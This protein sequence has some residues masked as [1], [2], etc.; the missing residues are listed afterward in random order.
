MI[1]VPN[2]KIIASLAFRQIKSSWAKNI[3][4]VL[5]VI[6][7][8]MLIMSVLTIG[9]TLIKASK[10]TQMKNSG[11][12]AEVSFQYLL[13]NEADSIASS[14]L[15]ER[16]GISR[17]VAGVHDA[18]WENTPL[19]IRTADETYADMMY[20]TPTDGRLPE[21][22][23]E[24]AVKS[25]MLSDMGIPCETG[26]SFPVS[27]DVNG[28]HYDLELTVSGIW[29]DTKTLFPFAAAYI[30][31]ELAEEL[32]RGVNT[33]ENISN[34]SYIGSFQLN[35]DLDCDDTKLEETLEQ[36]VAECGIDAQRSIPRVNTAF[37]NADTDAG[38][39][40]AVICILMIVM[41]SG[42]FLIYN[43]FYISVTKNI[44]SYGML[45]TIGTT[46]AQI[47]Q[48]VNIQGLIYCAAGIPCGL[49]AGYLLSVRLF[50]YVVSFASVSEKV[51]VVPGIAAVISA[52]LLSFITV[53]ISC[54]YPAKYASRITPIES[55]R[56]NGINEISHPSKKH[57]AKHTG[58]VQMSFSNLFRNKKKMVVTIVSV[59]LGMILVNV[60]YTFSNSFDVDS[61]VNS[62]IYGDLLA[63]D[64]SYLDFAVPYTE[65]A[66][67]L[68]KA[69]VDNISALDGI[70]YAAPVY[71]RC[72]DSTLINSQGE[73]TY[74]MLYGLDDHWYDTIEKY[75]TEGSF[76]RES[77]ASGRYIIISYDKGADIAIGDTVTVNGGK[78]YEVMGKVSYEKMFSLSA[79]YNVSVGFSAYLPADEISSMPDTDIMSI[80]L[81]AKKGSLS[82]LK[83]ELDIYVSSRSTGI[84]Y[85]ARSD[86]KNEIVQN[87]SQ[88]SIV[89]LTLSLVILL[90][91]VINYIN[92]SMSEIISRR[93]E[94]AVL[95]AIGMTSKQIRLMLISESLIFSFVVAAFFIPL[96]SFFSFFIIDVMLS[97]SGA[98][99]YQFSITPIAVIMLLLITI[100]VVIPLFV[101]KIVSKRN[102][103]EWLHDIS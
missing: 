48:I 88:F 44:R 50:P 63:A 70:E 84:S 53:F 99:S 68:T 47:K 96:G 92:T 3:F 78:T 49:M 67:T 69:D 57:E 45:K 103:I 18:P 75:I 98:F 12:K 36:L 82:K 80:S 15:T 28:R 14:S 64:K 6:L 30:S 74:S 24:V 9:N 23:N 89:G 1:R 10:S 33:E 86:Y 41:I 72:D 52:V 95:N 40:T 71:F 93:Y 58:I 55:L 61:M 34:G 62:Y 19:E 39:V 73:P 51:R 26:Q 59:V 102:T 42:Y 29:T 97:G 27:F 81:F 35:A 65:P 94:L 76:D 77:F 56:F 87:N 90:I 32:L 66:H 20:S 54:R 11:Q 13:E 2:N 85:S 5:A 100:S 46:S 22:K 21:K 91:G 16:C 101:Y 37:R 83:D 25:W 43:I 38:T 7:T 8:T 17:I 31:E 60:F 4:S 79:R